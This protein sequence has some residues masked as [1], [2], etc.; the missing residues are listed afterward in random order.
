[1]K[2]CS[3]EFHRQMPQFC[4]SHNLQHYGIMT[5]LLFN[6]KTQDPNLCDY[7]K[8]RPTSS[9][10]IPYQQGLPL[11]LLLPVGHSFECPL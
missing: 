6:K 4:M 5:I 8:P 1:M 3:T 2:I 11:P 10:I 7:R 9:V